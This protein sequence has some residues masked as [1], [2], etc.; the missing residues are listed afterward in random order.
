ME[1]IQYDPQRTLGAHGVEQAD[2][3]ALWPRLEAARQE[4]LEVD[5]PLMTSGGEVPA[6]KV[7][8]DAG[9]HDL[10]E[11]LLAAHAE[12]PEASEVGRILR[13]AQRLREA[14]DAQQQ[15]IL[16]LE[17]RNALLVDRIAELADTRAAPAGDERPPHY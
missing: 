17:R 5:L 6:E 3:E 10:P 1:T 8:L 11:R 2:L 12:D 15:Q 7:P 14:V 13:A 16:A 4:M 9:F